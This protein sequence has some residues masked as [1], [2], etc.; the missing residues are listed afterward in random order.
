MEILTVLNDYNAKNREEI[1]LTPFFYF[2]F[3]LEIN[4]IFLFSRK[5]RSVG[6]VEQ[7][8]NLEG[9]SLRRTS[10]FVMCL[11]KFVYTCHFRSSRPEVFGKKLVLKSFAKF[12]GKHLR[13]SLFLIKRRL[14]R[15]CFPVNFEK[16]LRSPL[17]AAS[18]TFVSYKRLFI[19]GKEISLVLCSLPQFCRNNICV[20]TIVKISNR[21][22][23]D[24]FNFHQWTSMDYCKVNQKMSFFCQP[25]DFRLI[26]D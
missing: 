4:I 1:H 20:I 16:F 12:T 26:S 18:V 9:L 14:W 10:N 17:V 13:K 3:W 2:L 19:I 15:R 8:I 24:L 7:L 21:S 22:I 6:P 25:G 11:L 23:Q 5:L